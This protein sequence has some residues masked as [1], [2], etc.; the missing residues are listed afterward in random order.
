MALEK[1][2][3]TTCDDVDIVV[4]YY[5]DAVNRK[6][7]KKIQKLAKDAGGFEN[8]DDDVLFEHAN[9]GKDTMAK[10]DEMSMRDYLKFLDQWMEESTVGES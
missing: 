10:I 4:P 8:L 6:G 3:F 9:I 2:H 1:F 5:L 7:M